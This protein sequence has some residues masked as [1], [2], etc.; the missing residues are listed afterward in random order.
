MNAKFKTFFIYFLIAFSLLT[1]SLVALQYFNTSTYFRILFP[2]AVVMLLTPR[3]HIIKSQSGNQ[4]G[5]KSI[6]FKKI[7]KIT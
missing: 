6:F 5:L 4:Y 7:I 3:P 2:V 1:L